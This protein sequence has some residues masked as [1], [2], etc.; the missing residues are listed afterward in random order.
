MRNIYEVKARPWF[1][2]IT[3]T[4]NVCA[5]S[6]EDA[7]KAVKKLPEL[8]AFLYNDNNFRVKQVNARTEGWRD[9]EIRRV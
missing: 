9:N 4:Y 1:G 7:K 6:P 2:N 5:K 3:S 8:H